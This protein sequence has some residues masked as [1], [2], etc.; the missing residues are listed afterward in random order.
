[1]AVTLLTSSETF[2]VGE[3]DSICDSGSINGVNLVRP[4]VPHLLEYL[5]RVISERSHKGRL[6]KVDGQVRDLDHEFIVL[7]R[8]G[9]TL[10]VALVKS[11]FFLFLK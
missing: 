4:F 6:R 7:S 3:M 10:I 8:C 9:N 2:E 5:S 11:W 1:M